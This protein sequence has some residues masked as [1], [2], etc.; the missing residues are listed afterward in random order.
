[1]SPSEA[2]SQPDQPRT[3]STQHTGVDGALEHTI[4]LHGPNVTPD[5]EAEPYLSFSALLLSFGLE[6][7]A[8][9]GSPNLKGS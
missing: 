2:E 9:A 8:S 5:R 6:Q 4:F 3:L 1:M 7:S